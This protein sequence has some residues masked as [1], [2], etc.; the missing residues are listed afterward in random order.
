MTEPTEPKGETFTK[1]YVENLRNE[2]AGHRLKAQE[3]QL[4]LDAA[5]TELTSYKTKFEAAD[6]ARVTAESAALEAKQ[7]AEAR[8]IGTELKAAARAAGLIDADDL[9]LVD[10]AA[11][12]IDDNGEIVGL[13]ELVEGFKTTKPHLFK[14]E[15]SPADPAAP[16][17][18]VPANSNTTPVTPPAPKAPG[19][20]H[21]KDMTPEEYAAEKARVIAGR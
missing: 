9:R 14:A 13:A 6:A 4:K 2:A 10:L 8:I 12:K 3:T 20:K 17:T 21:A 5:N 11:L 18:L 1:E 15:A 16:V 7:G 19:A